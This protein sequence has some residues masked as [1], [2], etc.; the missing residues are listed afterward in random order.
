M[1]RFTR[2]SLLS[3]LSSLPERLTTSLFQRPAAFFKTLSEMHSLILGTPS[4]AAAD[5]IRRCAAQGH[6]IRIMMHCLFYQIIQSQ[7]NHIAFF[8]WLW[9]THNAKLTASSHC[10]SYSQGAQNPTLR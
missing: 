3:G 8:C 7:Q 1:H 4:F 2:F 6:V 5:L 10:L 9:R